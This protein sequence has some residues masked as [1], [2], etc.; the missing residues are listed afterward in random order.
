MTGI[1]NAHTIINN[2][3]KS[4]TIIIVIILLYFKV[5]LV[6]SYAEH[7]ELKNFGSTGLSISMPT[8]SVFH[9]GC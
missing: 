8:I 7:F 9:C 1:N 6:N 5:R 2:Y 3:I 4:A